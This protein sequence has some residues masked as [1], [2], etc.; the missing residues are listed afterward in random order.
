MKRLCLLLAIV[1]LAFLVA[2][3]RVSVTRSMYD[4]LSVGMSSS[5]VEQ[6]MGL[7]PTTHTI[8]GPVTVDGWINSDGSRIDVK[9]RDD[10]LYEKTQSGLE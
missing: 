8:S 2:C 6:I 4:S 3:S 10:E 7:D 9:Y 1:L 5:Q